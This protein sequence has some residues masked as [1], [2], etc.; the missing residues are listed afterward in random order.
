[1]PADRESC[2]LLR[3]IVRRTPDAADRIRRRSD[4]V[5]N[6]DSLIPLAQEHGVSPMLFLRLADTGAAVPQAAYERLRADYERNAF[7]SLANASE[8][9]DLL[10]EFDREA[11]P[12]MPFKGVVLAASA[13]GDLA[14]RPAGDLDLL[15]DTRHLERAATLL[16]KRGYEL[17]TPVGADGMPDSEENFEYHF[18]RQADGMVIELRWRFDL[19]QPRFTRNLG[20]EW[21]WPRRRTA[22]LA[23]AEVP[24]LD[25][26]STLLVLCMHGSKH[27]W[28]RLIWVNDIAQVLNSFPDLDWKELT[29]E[30]RRSGLWRSLALGMLLEHRIADAT[31]PEPALRSFQSDA[32]ASSMAQHFEEVLFDA[33]GSPPIGR[34][35]YNI[36]LLDFHDRLRLFLSLDFLRPNARDRAAVRLPK[37]LHALYYLVRPIRLLWDRSAR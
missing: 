17:K 7:H 13:Y 34:E 36:R 4:A 30:A 21:V 5:R 27:A 19:T 2:E 12:V 22:R 24:S 14:T 3:A 15:I 31:V 18:E 35:P 32:A 23:G 28:S 6:W 16:V 8:L 10:K 9:I 1:M 26:E 33:P 20:M 25:P 29:R 37:S 11:I